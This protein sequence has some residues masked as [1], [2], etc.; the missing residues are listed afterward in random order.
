MYMTEEKKRFAV[1]KPRKTGNGAAV[2]FDF[3]EKIGA[4]FIEASSQ[5]GE[6]SFDWANKI[7][8]KLSMNDCAKIIAVIENRLKNADLF[9]DISKSKHVTETDVKNTTVSISKGDY[10]YFFKISR[11]KQDSS[12]QTIQTSLSEDEA[13]ILRILLSKAIEK[14]YW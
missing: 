14:T 10:G 3:N 9:H 6:Q 11:Q 7:V 12:L 2:Q 4:V 13:V 5:N 8:F 1:Y